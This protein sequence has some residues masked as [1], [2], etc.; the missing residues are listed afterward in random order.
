MPGGSASVATHPVDDFC[1]AAHSQKEE[2]RLVKTLQNAGYTVKVD[3]TY[4]KHGLLATAT[5]REREG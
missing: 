4:G 5:K 2:D 1:V 3:E